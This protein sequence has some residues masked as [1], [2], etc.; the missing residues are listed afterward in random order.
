MGM[1]QGIPQSLSKEI[2]RLPP[3]ADLFLSPFQDFSFKLIGKPNKCMKMIQPIER[4]V[5]IQKDQLIWGLPIQF[6][7]SRTVNLMKTFKS[8]IATLPLF[9][10]GIATAHS[11]DA[12]CSESVMAS[13][14]HLDFGSRF[15][16]FADQS[17][18]KHYVQIESTLKNNDDVLQLEG[19]EV[20]LDETQ[21]LALETSAEQPLAKGL[22]A[23]CRRLEITLH[24][25]TCI[26]S[27]RSTAE[28][29]GIVPSNGMANKVLEL[30]GKL[31]PGQTT[32]ITGETASHEQQIWNFKITSAY[33]YYATPTFRSITPTSSDRDYSYMLQ[34][35]FCKNSD[36]SE[37][38]SL[39]RLNSLSG[40]SLVLPEEKR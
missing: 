3:E 17:T 25:K 30:F 29:E 8:T 7:P 38:S 16:L 15:E 31:S 20:D 26:L 35:N 33:S 34:A 12:G 23:L 37:E 13:I 19:C 27:L 6:F 1:N 9:F 21:S 39:F 40:T 22:P 32:D 28:V 36:C 24:R 11:A 2:R 18:R 4:G 5:P 14:A 10:I